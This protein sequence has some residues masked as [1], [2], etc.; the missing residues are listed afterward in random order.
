PRAP[1][2]REPAADPTEAGQTPDRRPAAPRGS[3]R[4]PSYADDLSVGR[5]RRPLAEVLQRVL[6][7]AALLPLGCELGVGPAVCQT[8]RPVLGAQG[9][10]ALHIDDQRFGVIDDR[11]HLTR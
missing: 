4:R 8:A 11:E 9:T 2:A 6:G 3:G 10:R 5:A 7:W 1:G